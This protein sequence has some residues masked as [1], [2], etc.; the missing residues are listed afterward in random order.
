MKRIRGTAGKK[1]EIHPNFDWEAA[2]EEVTWE[3]WVR[4]SKRNH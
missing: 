3:I 2:R 1:Q 4:G